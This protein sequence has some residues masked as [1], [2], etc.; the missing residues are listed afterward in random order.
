MSDIDLTGDIT[1]AIDGAAERGSTL[2]LGY[3][4]PDGTAALSFRGSTQ[5]HS[6]DQLAL[7][8][9][10]KDGVFIESI[11]ERPVV[12]LL[13][14]SPDT[15]GAAYLSIKGRARVAPEA[16]DAVYAGMIEGERGQDPERK[17]VAVV[18]DV[19]SVIGAGPDGGFQQTR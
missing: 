6:Q 18:V 7:W 14:Y 3:V 13:Y 1:T 2:V 9:R 8:S 5:V 19:D 12:S 17:G 4:D 16:S 11:A 15:P 10:Q